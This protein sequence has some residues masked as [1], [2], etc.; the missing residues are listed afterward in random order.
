MKSY[1][2]PITGAPKEYGATSW[3][4]I[5]R[6]FIT[7][8]LSPL[9]NRDPALASGSGTLLFCFYFVFSGGWQDECRTTHFVFP[10]PASP[11][12]RG[13]SSA[14]PCPSGTSSP[15]TQQYSSY[16]FFIIMLLEFDS[17]G[18]E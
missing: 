15:Q 8:G 4:D 18:C 7:N 17:G 16:L 14:M 11:C 10:H 5:P 6:A 12:L 9:L 3:R 2:L 13:T 1:R